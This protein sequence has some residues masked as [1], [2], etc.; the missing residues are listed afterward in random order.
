[1]HPGH[2]DWI[3]WQYHNS[4]TVDGIEGPV[5]LNVL[6]GELA[7]LAAPAAAISQSRNTRMAGVSARERR[8][9]SQ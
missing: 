2:D 3:Y 5:D 6:Q 4:G 8:R 7:A 1:M 9:I